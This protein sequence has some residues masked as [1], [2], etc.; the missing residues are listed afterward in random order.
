MALTIRSLGDISGGS[1]TLKLLGAADPPTFCA[2]T[3]RIAGWV[4]L[5]CTELNGA[6]FTGGTGFIAGAG[7]RVIL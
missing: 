3:V 1:L 2:G 5:T 7:V 4:L 6:D